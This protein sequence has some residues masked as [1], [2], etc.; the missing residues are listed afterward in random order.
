MRSTEERALEIIERI[1]KLPIASEN[2]SRTKQER[3]YSEMVI[4]AHD[5]HRDI[6][7]DPSEYRD[8]LLKQ[9]KEYCENCRGSGYWQR[10][11]GG[12]DVTRPCPVCQ[13]Q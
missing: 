6:H 10:E 1:R 3:E 9:E 12:Q 13:K 7:R 11:G 2:I 8:H 5:L 4:M